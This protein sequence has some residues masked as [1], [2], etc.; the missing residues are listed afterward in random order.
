MPKLLFLQKND[1]ITL[2]KDWE[3]RYNDLLRGN[4]GFYTLWRQEYKQKTKEHYST[5]LLPASTK[6]KVIDVYGTFYKNPAYK[7]NVVE[8]QV[9]SEP[10]RLQ[11]KTFCVKFK[12]VN[13]CSVNNDSDYDSD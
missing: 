8:F 11:K 4:G 10:I 2:K 7:Y 9:V 5:L 3:F 1:T 13:K 6:L 12:E